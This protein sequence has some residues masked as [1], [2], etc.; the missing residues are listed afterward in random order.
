[1]KSYEYNERFTELRTLRA[2]PKSERFKHQIGKIKKGSFIKIKGCL[3]KVM[4]QYLY[5]HKSDEWTEYQLMTM[6]DGSIKYLEVE[7]DDE[8]ILTLTDKEIKL[9]HLDLT[10]TDLHD[11]WDDEDCDSIRYDDKL[12]E[13]EDCYKAQFKDVDDEGQSA[14]CIMYEFESYSGKKQ[15]ATIEDWDGVTKVFISSKLPL[16]KLEIVSI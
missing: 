10:K 11:I 16:N 14:S 12:Y 7:Y 13:F 15:F 8:F 6:S 4:K 3:F 1:M 2:T 9:R 5:T